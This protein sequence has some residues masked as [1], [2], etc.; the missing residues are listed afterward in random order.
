MGGVGDKYLPVNS[1]RGFQAARTVMLQ[2]L[3]YQR[4]Y[5][6]V[7]EVS[8]LLYGFCN[9]IYNSN[10]SLTITRAPYY[11]SLLRNRGQ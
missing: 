10:Q 3:A 7:S 2:S 4:L 11:Q 9:G 1:F 5:R 8:M 6:H